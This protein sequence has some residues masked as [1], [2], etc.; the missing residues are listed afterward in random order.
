[1]KITIEPERPEDRYTPFH[2]RITQVRPIVGTRSGYSCILEC[3]HRV[4]LFGKIE[5]A[6]GVALCMQCRTEAARRRSTCP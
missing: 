1:M 2:K 6:E 4:Q 3:G 5:M